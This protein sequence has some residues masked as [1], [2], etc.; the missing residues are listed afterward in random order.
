MAGVP[1]V[2]DADALN[3]MSRC[4]DLLAL[5]HSRCVLTPHPAEMARLIDAGTAEVLADPMGIAR[6]TAARFGCVVL[7]KGATSCISD[8]KDVFLNTSGNPGL[9]KGG[10]GDVLTGL[11]LAMLSQ[12]LAPL[13]AACAA[14]FL[15]GASADRA[16]AVLGNRMLLAGDVIDAI[17]QEIHA[18]RVR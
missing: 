9:A 3:A 13:K 18:E 14:A 16:Y 12:R 2:L 10:S 6:E 5:L 8:G 7:L 17:T 15:L 1:T 11:L 4:R